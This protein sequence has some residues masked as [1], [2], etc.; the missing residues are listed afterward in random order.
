MPPVNETQRSK[1]NEFGAFLSRINNI[2]DMLVNYGT[3]KNR[4]LKATNLLSTRRGRRKASIESPSKPYRISGNSTLTQLNNYNR[5]NSRLCISTSRTWRIST[6]ISSWS[7]VRCRH[8]SAHY[9]TWDNASNSAP[10]SSKRCPSHPNQKKWRLSRP[11][12]SL[13]SSFGLYSSKRLASTT[14]TSSEVVS[15]KVLQGARP[16][17]LFFIETGRWGTISELWK[18]PS[19][20]EER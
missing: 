17:V 6:S 15:S 8:S 7:N 9:H 10:R 4:S 12:V 5:A 1:V 19:I 18:Q 14:L 3:N 20:L 13:L 16:A 2:Y 11:N